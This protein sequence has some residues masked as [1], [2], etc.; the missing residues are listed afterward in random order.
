MLAMLLTLSQ[1]RPCTEPQHVLLH[2]TQ[3]L[4]QYVPHPHGAAMSGI[5][6]AHRPK[7]PGHQ[8]VWG[9]I[10]LLLLYQDI[11]RLCSALLAPLGLRKQ[12]S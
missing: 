4:P 3:P 12:Q 8:T 6:G 2:G 9:Q 11:A 10:M 5:M 1:S 7:E